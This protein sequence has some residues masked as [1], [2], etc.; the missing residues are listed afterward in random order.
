MAEH[1]ARRRAAEPAV[2]SGLERTFAFDDRDFGRVVK[3]IHA[4]AGIALGPHKRDM[5]YSRLVRRVRAGGFASFGVYL[6]A[7]ES[8]G[9][10]DEWQ[11]FVNALTTKNR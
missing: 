6:D 5:V 1:A 7:L 9:D 11:D 3:L 10:A 2:G 8:Q 4:R